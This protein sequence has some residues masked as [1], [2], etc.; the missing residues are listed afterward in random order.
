VMGDGGASTTGEWWT[1][2]KGAKPEGSGRS[3]R[4]NEKWQW[5]KE[6]EADGRDPYVKPAVT[7]CDA[8]GFTLDIYI[9]L[10][11]AAECGASI[12]FPCS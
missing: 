6:E 3:R 12:E 11:K 1:V 4:K 2:P 9:M 7:L 5:L 8:Q 10:V